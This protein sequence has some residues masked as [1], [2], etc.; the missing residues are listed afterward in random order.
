MSSS[1]TR[2]AWLLD[3]VI[4][5]VFTTFCLVVSIAI[6]DESGERFD[7]W[8]VATIIVIGGALLLRQR[9][10]EVALAITVAGLAVYT[11]AGF[12]GGPIYLAPLVPLYTI[13]TR[14]DRRRTLAVVLV[15]L[16]AF[17]VIGVLSD[18]REQHVVYMVAF[19][20]WV[21]GSVFLG[22]A[23]HNR[24]AYL[25][26][27][28]QRAR[29]LEESREEEAR[30]RVAEERLRIARDLHDV[31]AHG[32]AAIHMQSSVA[33]HVLERQPQQAAPALTAV[34]QLSK[35]TLN[36]LR[37]TLDVLRADD[38]SDGTPAPRAPTPGLA[39]LD[40][41][42]GVTRQAGLP[43][44][45]H[46]EGSA[47]PLP[48]ATDVAAYR[49]VQESLTNVMRHAGPSA[50]ATVSVAHRP[51]CVEI[52]VVDDGLGA[53]SVLGASSGHGILG[54]TERAAT[55]GGSVSARANPGG[56]FRVSAHLPVD[57]VVPEQNGAAR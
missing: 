48:T 41:L 19:A 52:E 46:V 1:Q 57:G 40:A 49:I 10:P 22:T 18:Q 9:A 14:G 47:V 30:R 13:A 44:E 35:Q 53:A 27:L 15:T 4:A 8:T 25:A 54:M 6:A 43:V 31:I 56:G 23:Q 32:I 37:A 26:Q 50:H 28:E 34:K 38:G 36:D 39:Q 5:A 55:V 21:G 16:G 51:G 3:A 42:V 45:V 33:L 7:G 2:R 20:G 11:F 24:R 29:D 17:L 12:A